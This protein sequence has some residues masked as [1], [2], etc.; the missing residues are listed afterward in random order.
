MSEG[1]G[2]KSISTCANSMCVHLHVLVGD[3]AQFHR[4]AISK[5]LVVKFISTCANMQ[6]CMHVY[7]CM[8]V[9]SS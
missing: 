3:R 8:Y 7:M 5:G 1:L 4:T 9:R 6:T 2:V